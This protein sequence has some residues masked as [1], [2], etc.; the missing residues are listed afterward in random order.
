MTLNCLLESKLVSLKV[1]L[2][3]S[4]VACL[5]PSLSLFR[6]LTFLN[7]VIK[8]SIVKTCRFRLDNPARSPVQ[9]AEIG[10]I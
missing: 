2:E 7:R 10:M 9:I 3:G 8:V 4:P 6:F 1:V 5:Q